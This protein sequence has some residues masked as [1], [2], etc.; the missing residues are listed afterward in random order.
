[1]HSWPAVG[2]RWSSWAWNQRSDEEV[3]SRAAVEPV[4]TA[5]LSLSQRRHLCDSASRRFLGNLWP[6]RPWSVLSSEPAGLGADSVP[7]CVCNTAA[8]NRNPPSTAHRPVPG[9]AAGTLGL[10]RGEMREAR[11]PWG[12]SGAIGKKSQEPGSPREGRAQSLRSR[13]VGTHTCCDSGK[14]SAFLPAL[15]LPLRWG[16]EETPLQ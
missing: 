16:V 6:G 7:W 8:T 13:P 5:P 12:G 10:Q 2:P 9:A 14:V 4:T 11:G 3:D 15:V 1:M